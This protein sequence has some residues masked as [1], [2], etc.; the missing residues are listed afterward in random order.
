[1][2]V[3][4]TGSKQSQ[5]DNARRKRK[6]QTRGKTSALPSVV[7]VTWLHARNG[8]ALFLL[9]DNHSSLS[10]PVPSQLL[11]RLFY[12]LVKWA[13]NSMLP[14]MWPQPYQRRRHFGRY[15]PCNSYDEDQFIQGERG[16][17]R[18]VLVDMTI[19]RFH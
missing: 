8:L 5:P 3:R 7:H 6:T 9:L 18:I 4:V 19:N 14:S 16:I 13:S 12:G 10:I 2:R 17:P 15:V 1:M 11:P